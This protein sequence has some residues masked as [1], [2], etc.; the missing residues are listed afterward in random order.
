MAQKKKTTRRKK[1]K[2]A[3][4]FGDYL[5]VEVLVVAVLLFCFFAWAISKCSSG[6]TNVTPG[7]TTS[8]D[9]YESPAAAETPS[10]PGYNL[11]ELEP[12][13]EVRAGQGTGDVDVVSRGNSGRMTRR[14]YTPL[15]V[16]LDG[17]KVR[18]GPSRD[19]V[20]L[21]TLALHEEVMFMEKRT[22]FKEKIKISANEIT[23]EPWV[24][25]QTRKGHK[26]WVYGAGIHYYKWDRLKNPIPTI[27]EEEDVE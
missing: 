1:N 10:S 4:L 13:P 21:T 18:R 2:F 19:S 7:G 15:Y 24:F 12:A 6:P 17:L 20:V 23:F 9:G 26:G 25:I 5:R 3:S 27:N 22:D 14:S 8:N 16:T 11:P